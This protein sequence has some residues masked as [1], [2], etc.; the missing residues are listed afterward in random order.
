MSLD[1]FFPRVSV[2]AAQQEHSRSYLKYL[3]LKENGFWWIPEGSR[4]FPS[5]NKV[6]ILW[7]QQICLC[8]FPR[9][10]NLLIYIRAEDNNTNES[11]STVHVHYKYHIKQ[12]TFHYEASSVA[13]RGRE[14]ILSVICVASPQ[15]LLKIYF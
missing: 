14:Q 1:Y 10:V 15:Y 5:F 9:R 7:Y 13:L 8:F 6:L 12:F 11:L 4:I 3:H 2:L